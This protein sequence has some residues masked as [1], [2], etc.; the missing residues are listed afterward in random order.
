[1][2]TKIKM[3]FDAVELQ[4]R[5]RTEI[6]KKILGLSL[7]EEIQFFNEA[8]ERAKKRRARMQDSGSSRFRN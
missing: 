2:K 8:S 1:M 5:V 3:A 7:E 4:H 6:G